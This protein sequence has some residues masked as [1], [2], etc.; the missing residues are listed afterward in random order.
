[1]YHLISCWWSFNGLF[2]SIKLYQQLMMWYLSTMM[3]NFR[4]F[5]LRLNFAVTFNSWKYFKYFT[6]CRFLITCITW[7]NQHMY[8]N[9]KSICTWQLTLVI[10]IVIFSALLAYVRLIRCFLLHYSHILR[11]CVRYVAPIMTLPIDFLTLYM[12]LSLNM[13][14]FN[15]ISRMYYFF[16]GYSFY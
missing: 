6:T 14:M 15:Y 3:V 10:I 8:C 2:E 16:A 13:N 9:Y 11:T 7:R 5:A 12:F 4:L 1:M